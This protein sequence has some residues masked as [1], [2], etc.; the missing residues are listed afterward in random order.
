MTRAAPPHGKG[1]RGARLL[2]GW[3]GRTGPAGHATLP[4]HLTSVLEEHSCQPGCCQPDPSPPHW[5]LEE[6]ALVRRSKPR[7]M[8]VGGHGHGALP[9]Q[10]QREPAQA[11]SSDLL[12]TAL[13]KYFRSVTLTWLLQARQRLP[14][15]A[16]VSIPSCPQPRAVTAGRQCLC[17]GKDLGTTSRSRSPA[18]GRHSPGALQGMRSSPRLFPIVLGSRPAEPVLQAAGMAS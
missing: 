12:I 2:E 18:A 4:E 8:P 5:E 3:P 9:K 15:A 1:E 6:H 14:R 16:A 7:Q 13:V 17:Q 11:A 10:G